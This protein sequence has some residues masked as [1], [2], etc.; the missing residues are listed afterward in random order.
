VG[1]SVFKL[2]VGHRSKPI[3]ASSRE[4]PVSSISHVPHWARIAL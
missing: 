2:Q 1:R 4:T 3:S